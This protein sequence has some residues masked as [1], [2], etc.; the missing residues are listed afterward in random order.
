MEYEDSWPKLSLFRLQY[1][2]PLFSQIPNQEELI[3]GIRFYFDLVIYYYDEGDLLVIG[4]LFS[5]TRS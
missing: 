2:I 3:I 5:L 1:L 4:F